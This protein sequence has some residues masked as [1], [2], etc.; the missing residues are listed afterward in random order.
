MLVHQ[1]L[2]C[3]SGCHQNDGSGWLLVLQRTD[4]VYGSKSSGLYLMCCIFV[5]GSSGRKSLA[6]LQ[7][8]KLQSSSPPVYSHVIKWARPNI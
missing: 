2:N 3:G 6:I 1:R 8:L 5:Y 7:K 4:V